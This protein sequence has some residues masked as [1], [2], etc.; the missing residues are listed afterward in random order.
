[1]SAHRNN[2]QGVKVHCADCHLPA[3][4]LVA[5]TYMHAT[6]GFRD[7]LASW[8]HDYSNPA[9]WEKRRVELAREVR[10]DM[11]RNDSI[12]CRSCHTAA[13]VEPA[14]ES[15]QA[16]HALMRTGAVTCIDCHFNLVHAPV[17]PSLSFIRSSGLG[18]ETK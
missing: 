14:S 3:T 6:S 17:P 15:G 13:S 7:I 2:A 1:M 18:G 5:E 9:T 12:A 10:L 8:T 11:R 4:N 16:A